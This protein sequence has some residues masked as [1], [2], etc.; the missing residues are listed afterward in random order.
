MQWERSKRRRNTCRVLIQKPERK[1]P[2]G[3]PKHE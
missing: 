2:L 1:R 3:R